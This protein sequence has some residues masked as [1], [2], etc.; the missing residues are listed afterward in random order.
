MRRT[1]LRCGLMEM[2]LL[3]KLFAQHAAP[4]REAHVRGF[5][6]VELQRHRIPHFVDPVGNLVLGADSE[7]AYKRKVSKRSREPL[8]FFIAHMDHPGFH[9]VRWLDKKRLAVK[10]FGGSPTKDLEGAKVW[11]ADLHTVFGSA[12]L[13]RVK[14]L[15]SGRAIDTAEVVVGP[16]LAKLPLPD[17]KSLYGGLSFRAPVWSVGQRLYTKAADDLCGVYCILSLAKHLYRAKKAHEN[18]L[19]ILTRAEEVGFIGTIGHLELGWLRDPG[20]AL[21]NVNLEASRTLPGAEIGKGP[22]VRLGDRMTVFDPGGIRVMTDLSNKILKGKYQRRIMD[23]GACE[24]SAVTAYGMRAIGLSVP[25]G[26]YHNQNFEG[27]PDS[28]AALGPAPEFVDKRDLQGML[29]LCVALMQ[30]GLGW[31]APWGNT[32]RALKQSLRTYRAEMRGGFSVE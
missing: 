14:L 29:K 20:R 8:R 27:G 15:K 12:S 21:L 28:R 17:A 26:N 9:G 1:L 2:A 4:F 31:R 6:E 32:A 23:G 24:A 5:L 7:S 19:G 30:S 11:L 25:L 16:Q 3:N 13:R 10:W 22:I 18:F